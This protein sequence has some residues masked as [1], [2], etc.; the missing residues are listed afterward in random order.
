MEGRGSE[1]QSEENTTSQPIKSPVVRSPIERTEN[2]SIDTTNEFWESTIPKILKLLLIFFILFI[3]V[4]IFAPSEVA[5]IMEDE[6]EPAP[7]GPSIF[8][9]TTNANQSDLRAE[10]ECTRVDFLKENEHIVVGE[11]AYLCTIQIFPPPE[12]SANADINVSWENPDI[13]WKPFDTAEEGVVG[14]DEEQGSAEDESNGDN[15]DNQPAFEDRVLVRAPNSPG[16]YQLTITI[17]FEG[18][19]DTTELKATSDIAVNI[20]SQDDLLQSQYRALIFPLQAL[21]TVAIIISILQ[22]II[23]IRDR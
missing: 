20:Y 9:F 5:S 23:M 1:N 6:F 13:G 21:V 17:L 16:P 15:G 4:L 19:P 12:E 2:S 14:V 11:A 7:S 22:T 3:F 18:Q 10:I 8:K